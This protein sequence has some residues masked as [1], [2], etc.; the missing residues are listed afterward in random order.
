MTTDIRVLN[1]ERMLRN[2]IAGP[3]EGRPNRQEKR[4]MEREARRL[5]RKM[6]EHRLIHKLGRDGAPRT[7]QNE[8][9]AKGAESNLARAA[10][11]PGFARTR[12]GLLISAVLAAEIVAAGCGS[13]VWDDDADTDIAA[14]IDEDTPSDVGDL[15]DVEDLAE[16]GEDV[17]VPDSEDAEVEAGPDAD[18][19][20]VLDIE[21]DGD[22]SECV[23]TVRDEPD[24][25]TGP[26]PMCGLT[27]TNTT[28]TR[29]TENR[30]AGC[31]APGTARLM[32]RKEMSLSS[33]LE[34]T[35]LGCARG[36][37]INALN[38]QMIV[39]GLEPG[40]IE[41]AR[42]IAKEILRAEESVGGTAG[43]YTLTLSGLR[44]DHAVL[45]VYG[46]TGDLLG[47]IYVYQN[48]YVVLP[49]MPTR[50][51]IIYRLNQ[52]AGTCGVAIIAL[53]TT[54]LNNGDVMPWTSGDWG[55]FTF[56]TNTVGSQFF[57]LGWARVGI[58]PLD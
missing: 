27:Q 48:G 3:Q 34:T 38:E 58:R 29:V 17:A 32:I 49:G 33:A 14:D 39:V 7:V 55:E 23:E 53:P 56:N 11:A 52:M 26:E 6:E 50:A 10:D 57:G 24:T 44:P 12:A 28:T 45:R 40:R 42:K 37:D 41:L 16:G 18:A 13:V 25:I 54:I 5:A 47:N 1:T 2:K 20:D 15:A 31:E 19:E 43:E 9:G 35:G 8:E 21:A 4:G 51:A 22:V 46:S 30:G 36:V